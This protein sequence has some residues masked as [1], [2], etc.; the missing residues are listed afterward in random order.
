MKLNAKLLF[1]SM[2]VT[3][4]IFAL[5]AALGAFNNFPEVLDSVLLGL[6]TLSFIVFAVIFFLTLTGTK[7]LYSITGS[8]Y[9]LAS[10]VLGS[11]L[12]IMSMSLVP[13]DSDPNAPLGPYTLALVTSG[14][15]VLL[16]FFQTFYMVAIRA[17][18]LKFAVI[19][20]LALGL[21]IWLTALSKSII[22]PLGPIT[23][24]ATGIAALR[25]K[26]GNSEKI[27]GRR[28]R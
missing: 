11:V 21:L 1:Q 27:S 23:L 3:N 8:I 13:L 18:Q 4:A 6:L 2:L 22:W 5:S 12:F 19:Y 14:L 16:T 20:L 17:D 24:I 10:I 25:I 26:P 7:I 28:K 15:L 9:S